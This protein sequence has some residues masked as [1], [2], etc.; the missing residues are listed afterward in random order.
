MVVSRR[1]GREQAHWALRIS[2]IVFA[3]GLAIAATG[4]AALEAAEGSQAEQVD[5]AAEMLTTPAGEPVWEVKTQTAGFGPQ[6]V[7]DTVL[8]YI[9]EEGALKLAG[10]DLETGDEKWKTAAGTGAQAPSGRVPL[11]LFKNA[12]GEPQVLNVLAPVN[13]P[14]PDGSGFY[15]HPLQ[16]ID[17]AT[18]E[19]KP[20]PEPQY[21][22]SAVND[23]CV[24]ETVS[25]TLGQHPSDSS[26]HPIGI[27]ENGEPVTE[28][29]L[30]VLPDYSFLNGELANG[31]VLGMI[32][33]GAASASLVEDGAE[34]WRVTLK[35]LGISGVTVET[36]NRQG[37]KNFMSQGHLLKDDDVLLVSLENLDF[38]AS[39]VATLSGGAL[40]ALDRETGEVLWS[41]TGTM[42]ASVVCAGSPEVS[43]E[44]NKGVWS[45][46]D[47]KITSY[48]PRSGEEQWSIEL[49]DVNPYSELG[50]NSPSDSLLLLET[51]SGVQIVETDDGTVRE[52]LPD[53]VFG[54]V[55]RVA[56]YQ[57]HEFTRPDNP[58]VDYTEN[59]I[60]ASC[61]LG[62]VST[63]PD[64]FS[65]AT[66]AT[67][68]NTLFNAPDDWDILTPQ[69][70]VIPTVN[71]IALYE[72]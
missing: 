20:I 59:H 47:Y 53:E 32:R 55:E 44:G 24:S 64:T 34:R 51:A 28:P 3:S 42:C 30:D 46:A 23:N 65:Q 63:D 5:R 52:A 67:N 8:S 61:G 62:G 70:R 25:C 13:L 35:D 7:G 37:F 54:C 49:E 56:A 39:N 48:E 66:V 38:N 19:A 41:T 33:D 43:N 60:A 15:K 18:G 58:V 69:K 27:D 50:W 21:W 9:V 1:Q 10:Y 6:I 4:C 29:W 36:E 68:T 40:T 14:Q 31:I 57:Q 17:V 11:R 71:G 26:Y 2:G 72:F 22:I 12:A 16:V 45:P